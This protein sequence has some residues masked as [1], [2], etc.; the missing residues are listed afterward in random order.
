MSAKLIHIGF[1]NYFNEDKILAIAVPKSSPIKRNMVVARDENRLIDL[2]NGR[3]TKSVIFT[4]AGSVVLSALEPVTIN[5][6]LIDSVR[7]EGEG[8]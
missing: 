4:D 1:G 8:C 3:R 2:T 7:V 6:R 5:G